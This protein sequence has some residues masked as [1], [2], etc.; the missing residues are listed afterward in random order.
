MAKFG[1]DK[2]AGAALGAAIVLAPTEANGLVFDDGHVS[3]GRALIAEQIAEECRGV[4]SEERS[5]LFAILNSR[6]VHASSWEHAA[7]LKAQIEANVC[8]ESDISTYCAGVGRQVRD[9]F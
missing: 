3:S 1:L 6:E 9:E 8:A 4:G 2:I 5:K 7:E